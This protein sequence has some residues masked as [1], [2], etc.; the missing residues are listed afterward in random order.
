M[1]IEAILNKCGGPLGKRKDMMGGTREKDKIIGK[2]I[3]RVHYM[4]MW[5]CE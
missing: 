2:N 5:I 3:V 4:S 1:L